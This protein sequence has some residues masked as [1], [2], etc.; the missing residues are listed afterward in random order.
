MLFSD[1]P[2]DHYEDCLE[3]PSFFLFSGKRYRCKICPASRW[4]SATQAAKHEDVIAHIVRVCELD[5][6]TAAMSSD[7]F[8]GPNMA[9][10]VVWTSKKPCTAPNHQLS[11]LPPS[12]PPSDHVPS[13]SSPTS[14]A[15]ETKPGLNDG[16]SE[17]E[18]ASDS[19][20]DPYTIHGPALLSD[21]ANVIYD[22]WGGNIACKK[23]SMTALSL[24]DDKPGGP[25][26]EVFIDPWLDLDALDH[27]DPLTVDPGFDEL[28][29]HLPIDGIQLPNKDVWFPWQ[30]KKHCLLDILGAFL[31][32]AFSEAEMEIT[33][34]VAAKLGVRNLPSIHIVK[35]HRS[36][37]LKLAGTQPQ[38]LKSAIG[39]LYCKT[40]LASILAHEVANPIV[41]QL[42]EFYPEDSGPR[43]AEAR[44]G[45]Y[46]GQDYFVSEPAL[47]TVDDIGTIQPVIPV[48][49]FT[50]NKTLFA[51]VHCLHVERHANRDS[52]VVDASGALEQGSMELPL[53]AFF[54]SYPRLLESHN[55]YGLPPPTRIA[56]I[57][58]S[59]ASNGPGRAAAVFDVWK[60]PLLNPWRTKAQGKRVLVL[61]LWW[62]CDDTSSNS[63]KKWNKHNSFLCV[64]AG[65][66]CK[67]VHLAYNIHFLA[68]SNI[69]A[70]LEMF[71][72]IAADLKQ[73]QA[74][75]LVA[76]DCVLDEDVVYIPWALACLGDNPMQSELSSHI[77]LQGKWFCRVCH[78]HGKDNSLTGEE[79]ERDC[80]TSFLFA[81]DIRGDFWL[82]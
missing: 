22:N 71:E 29:E 10:H 26:L 80:L 1:P 5:G 23:A 28:A 48:R 2:M 54:L 40:S 24:K 36:K 76:W 64:L 6:R 70:L 27:S 58:R 65:L 31:C 33:R 47:A 52:F 68:T 11:P 32:A 39:N 45:E 73:M 42:L 61:P 67:H 12:S 41:W 9:E 44:Q 66:P 43:L 16:D 75:G 7:S 20:V 49:F 81:L 8:G 38:V 78:A 50:R 35:I 37:V 18:T 72:G 3:N 82:E 62:Y 56:G 30:N 53:H 13:Q 60:A 17:D 79:G 69:A 57:C 21:D 74:D 51:K 4:Q 19:L 34:W 55:A 77:G 25:N 63:S 46:D 14:L 15:H 59:T